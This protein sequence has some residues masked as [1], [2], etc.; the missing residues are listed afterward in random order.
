MS[1]RSYFVVDAFTAEPFAG[2][3]A[4]VVPDAEGL[5][6]RTM[7]AIAAEFNLSE[8]TFVLP[9]TERSDAH[10]AFR[11]RW[12]TPTTEVDMCGHATVAGVHALAESGRIPDDD[13][14]ASVPVRIE[15]RGGT[16]T[17]F[18][19]RLPG[20]PSRRV[21]WLQLVD[22]ILSPHNADRAALAAA[23][24]LPCDAFAEELPVMRTQDRDLLVFVRSFLAMN[25]ARPDFARLAAWMRREDL[26]G[27][28]LATANT[29]TPSVNLQSRFFAPAAGVDED[30]VTGSV[31]G[32]LAA[33][34][35]LH[36]LVPL[37]D[38]VAGMQCVQ[39][40]AGGR[41][42][43]IWALVS[44]QPDGTFRVRIGGQAVTIMR[45]SLCLAAP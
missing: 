2:N 7:Q 33:Y 20:D 28:S 8:T 34:A 31:H 5:D 30:P 25:D 6:E 35:V 4:A 37:R 19:E 15:T 45:G 40:K 41:A 36:G 44:V 26:R 13:D 38:G 10:P 18:L 9:P 27:L 14:A 11:F 23:L 24:N 32:P 42:G 1:S 43:L 39:A 17:A 12:F 22:P 29:I 21:V 16:L 3:P